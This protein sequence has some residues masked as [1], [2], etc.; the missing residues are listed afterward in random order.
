M[1]QRI[2]RSGRGFGRSDFLAGSETHI[3]RRRNRKVGWTS[4]P[5]SYLSSESPPSHFQLAVAP[6]NVL[7][8]TMIIVFR[9]RM[10]DTGFFCLNNCVISPA[11]LAAFSSVESAFTRH[12]CTL[13]PSSPPAPYIQ[14]VVNM[15]KADG[16]MIASCGWWS[17]LFLLFVYPPT[18]RLIAPD[19]SSVDNSLILLLFPRR[20]V[21]ML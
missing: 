8:T 5:T 10:L 20:T 7:V 16:F 9:L 19:A 13:T 21:P 11:T 4:I 6:G 3:K 2:T 17:V 12:I 1:S 14:R 18:S 15:V